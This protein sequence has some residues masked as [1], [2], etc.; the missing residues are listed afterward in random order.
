MEAARAQELREQHEEGQEEDFLQE[1][2]QED[3][4]IA[5]ELGFTEAASDTEERSAE[6]RSYL[7]WL[8]EQARAVE[9]ESQELR[10][11]ARRRTQMI[12][13]WAEEEERK[14]QRQMEYLE[15]K[16]RL[17]VGADTAHF[18]R[19]YG[20]RKKSLSLPHGTVGFRA[21]RDTVAITDEQEALEY[22]KSNGLEFGIKEYPYKKALTQH[23]QESGLA[24][25]PG[26]EAVPGEDQFVLKPKLD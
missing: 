26:W 11:V 6:R 10:E 2:A 20:V 21:S 15:S 3:E 19:I 4:R 9:L 8:L 16:A 23:W 18:Q 13:S 7:D 24:D 25:G 1:L 14:L 22:S 17:L 12:R 5:R